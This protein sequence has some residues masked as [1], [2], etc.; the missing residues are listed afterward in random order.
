VEVGTRVDGELFSAK[1]DLARKRPA[2]AAPERIECLVG[3]IRIRW[4]A[5]SAIQVVEIAIRSLQYGR[6]LAAH[7]GASDYVIVATG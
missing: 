6:V 2:T 4:A 3:V 5:S 1:S 7:W